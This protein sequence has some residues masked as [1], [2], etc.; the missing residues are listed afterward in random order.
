MGSCAPQRK[1]R[2]SPGAGAAS[3]EPGQP[4][5]DEGCTGPGHRVVSSHLFPL[6]PLL[7]Q[8]D[9]PARFL[10]APNWLCNL[11]PRRPHSDLSASTYKM[12]S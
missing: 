8:G 10:S 12:G 11:G 7:I 5:L 6:M 9:S 4:G 3:V 2:S 1:R